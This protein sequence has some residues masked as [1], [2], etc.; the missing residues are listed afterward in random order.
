MIRLQFSARRSPSS[1]AIRYFTWSPYSH[2]DFILPDGTLLGARASRGV[3]LY[4]PTEGA[5]PSRVATF[6][7]PAADDVADDIL[8][9]VHSQLGKP[10]DWGGVFGIAS[11]SRRWQ[12][13]DA[14]FCSEL[15]DWAFGNAGAPLLRTTS[16]WRVTPR[17]LLLSPLLIPL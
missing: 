16:S 13:T 2:V 15:V 14:W 11:R 4:S 1:A 5:S 17:D 7:V 10:Y 6:G 8:Q 12:Q 3:A 9:L